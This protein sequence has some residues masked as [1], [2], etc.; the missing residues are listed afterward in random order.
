MQSQTGFVALSNFSLI[1]PFFNALIAI[2][3][4]MELRTPSNM[5]KLS[6]VV[7]MARKKPVVKY[8]SAITGRYVRPWVAKKYPK[9]TVKEIDKPRKRGK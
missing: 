3:R 2:I 4:V 9:T 6:E 8:R 5:P 1:N 7:I